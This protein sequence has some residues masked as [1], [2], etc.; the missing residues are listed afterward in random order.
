MGIATRKAMLTRRPNDRPFIITRS[1]FAGAGKYMSKWLGDNFSRWDHYRAQIP[2][3][4]AF[5]SI[6]QIPMV[7]SDVC[8][9]IGAPSEH[10]CARWATL[11]AFNPFFRNHATSD[12]PNQEF[13]LWEL[14]TSAAK[15]AI[16]I[17]YRLLDYLYT[18][19]AR[20]SEDGTPSLSP[21]WHWY[22]QD[23]NTWGLDMQFFYGDCVMVSPV[24]GDEAR[25]VDIYLPDDIFYTWE[26]HRP[27]RG[28]G[29]WTKIKNV[30]FD[31]LPI[32][33]RGGC[34]VP[35]RAESANTTTALR[36]QPFEV[37]VAPGLDGHA[38]GTLY[39]DDGI[40]LDGGK[41]KKHV[42]FE[43]VGGKLKTLLGSGEEIQL[44]DA[45][46]DV[47]KVTVLE[48]FSERDDREEL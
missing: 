25:D 30:P 43:Y 29:E 16:D 7:G 17:R 19:L 33:I 21:L 27:V 11:G 4:L 42:H 44:Q 31:R 45:G 18:A 38:R 12:A 37:L 48:A 15:Y 28:R 36:Q 35:L 2:Q 20:Q 41:H 6:F 9:F 24:T 13:Y 22:P 40:S 10:L 14:V 46:I 34:I 3:M 1:T 5:A 39:L 32:H 47:A 8:G 26:D 23:E